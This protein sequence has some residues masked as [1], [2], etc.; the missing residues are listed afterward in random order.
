VLAELVERGGAVEGPA[1]RSTTAAIP[2]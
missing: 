2:K 1:L